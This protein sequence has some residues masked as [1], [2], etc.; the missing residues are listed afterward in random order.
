[1]SKIHG[2]SVI[3]KNKRS[4]GQKLSKIQREEV[5]RL[6]RLHMA[7]HPFASK[8]S[9][10]ELVSVQTGL[11]IRTLYKYATMVEKEMLSWIKDRDIYN[12]V[13]MLIGGIEETEKTLWKDIDYGTA[14]ERLRA[15]KL[16]I[17]NRLILLKVM[18]EAGTLNILGRY[19]VG[20]D[21]GKNRLST[22]EDFMDFRARI[23]EGLSQVGITLNSNKNNEVVKC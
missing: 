19:G 20:S 1:M 4:R 23:E 13:G 21:I 6:L 2:N 22:K 11:S 18:R 17:K 3:R 9:V 10:L 16:L 7:K 14:K 15:I 8:N 12:A 5:K